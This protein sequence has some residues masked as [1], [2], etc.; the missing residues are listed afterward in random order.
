MELTSAPDIR[1]LLERHG[2]R[3]SKA[4][5]QNF[6]IAPWVPERIAEE[7]GLDGRTGVVEA[8]PGIGCLTA[9][10]AKRAGRVCAVELD[11]SLA[12]ILEETLAGTENVDVVYGDALKLD[13]CK[14]IDDRLPG[15]RPVVCANLPYNVTSPLLS[16]F[17]DTGR[18]DTITVMVQREVARRLCAVESTAEYGA[19]TIYVNWSYA[20]EILFDVPPQCFMPA[21]KVTSSVIRLTRRE[22][23]AATVEDEALMF[24]VVRAAFSQRRKTLQ[25][26]LSNGLAGYSRESVAAAI[27]ACGLDP[28]VRGEALSVQMFAKL[29]DLLKNRE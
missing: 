19:F 23:T 13:L 26:A 4:L 27:A 9:E 25:N 8:G 12:P 7:A 24:R 20:P 5:G 18:F 28:L 29:A 6:L 21:P 11:R 22:G 3:F 14:L 16:A 2:F 17:I 10:L 15:L 1:L